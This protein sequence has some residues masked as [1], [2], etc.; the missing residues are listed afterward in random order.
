ML[1]AAFFATGLFTCFLGTELWFVESMVVAMPDA[2]A[3]ARRQGR[4]PESNSPREQPH[5]TVRPAR[6]VGV[7]LLMFG[8]L[9]M[10]Y[11]VG[12]PRLSVA[13]EPAPRQA[14]PLDAA[15]GHMLFLHPPTSEHHDAA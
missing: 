5:G 14:V 9:T 10:V 13:L 12:L 7:S 2:P 11:A 15:H 6:W 3:T 1:R 8:G 4:Q